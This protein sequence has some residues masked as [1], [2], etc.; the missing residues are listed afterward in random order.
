MDVA[1]N[2]QL[3]YD[4]SCF[5]QYSV[6]TGNAMV[7][8][9]N[10]TYKNLPTTIATSLSQ[11]NTNLNDN[12]FN[13]GQL[14]NIFITSNI[15]SNTSNTL[16]NYNNLYNRPIIFSQ[17]DASNIFITSNILSNTS[18]NLANYNNLNNKVWTSNFNASISKPVL[19]NLS[20]SYVGIG[21]NNPSHILQVGNAGRLQIANDD[22]EYSQIGTDDNDGIN[23][24]KIKLSGVNKSKGSG[25]IEYNASCYFGCHI[26]NTNNYEALR[27]LH[28]GNV[29]IGVANTLFKL[30]VNGNI[31]ALEFYKN[32]NNISNIFVTQTSLNNSISTQNLNATNISIRTSNIVDGLQLKRLAV[33]RNITYPYDWYSFD[34]SMF[35]VGTYINVFSDLNNVKAN[36]YIDLSTGVYGEGKLRLQGNG[37]TYLTGDTKLTLSSSNNITLSVP[38]GKDIRLEGNVVFKDGVVTKKVPKY[39]TTSRTANFDGISCLAYDIDL[40]K[41]AGKQTIDAIDFRHFRMKVFFATGRFDYQWTP[42]TFDVSMSTYNALSISCFDGMGYVSS[43]DKA[44]NFLYKQNIDLITFC[45]PTSLFGTT[46]LKIGYVVEDLLGQ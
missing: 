21:T 14:S 28:S 15:L 24:T 46:N 36:D 42:R 31:N 45:C 16:A 30:D 3:S 11:I 13:K 22:S 9:L 6:V 20:S 18:N 29:G 26:F 2:V 39:F 43:L 10:D 40:T 41:I 17:T 4:N 19:Y 38:Q 33:T 23:N 5:S 7:L 32:N 25:N 34:G 44:L 35:L 27:I 1:G 8:T 12:Y 37:Y